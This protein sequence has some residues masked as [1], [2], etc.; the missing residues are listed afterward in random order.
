MYPLYVLMTY[1]LYLYI[2]Y[3]LKKTNSPQ[4]I[5]I[6]WHV[7]SS[8]IRFN[9]VGLQ[10]PTS[11]PRA[12]SRS[13]PIDPRNM[14]KLI[15]LVT[16]CIAST[17]CEAKVTAKASHILVKSK[18]KC[19]E[20]KKEI[21]GGA[22]FAMAAKKYSSCPSAKRGGDLGTFSPGSMV[23]QFNDVVFN[24]AVGEVHG[25]VKTQF[26]YHLILTSERSD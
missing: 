25:C 12:Q 1:L 18:T 4:G 3:L 7:I 20:I 8:S 13:D 15:A 21:A 17:T 24:E 9:I 22:D 5:G 11:D 10:D 16:L 23:K 2:I 14:F 26:G 19:L 6:S